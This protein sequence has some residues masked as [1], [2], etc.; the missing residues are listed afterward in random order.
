MRGIERQMKASKDGN[1]YRVKRN[2]EVTTLVPAPHLPNDGK[3][4]PSVRSD[5]PY[6]INKVR[7]EQMS[8]MRPQWK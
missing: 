6:N 3:A 5:S 7:V 4:G 2:V 1:V 8:R